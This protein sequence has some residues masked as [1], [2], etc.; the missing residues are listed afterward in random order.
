MAA[1][2]CVVSASVGSASAIIAHGKDG[3][4]ID[5]DPGSFAD[6]IEKLASDRIARQRIGQNAIATAKC[7]QWSEV[8]DDVVRSYRN[9]IAV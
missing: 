8:L 7:Y 6:A 4:L 9:L 5:P 3:L 1:G 2:I